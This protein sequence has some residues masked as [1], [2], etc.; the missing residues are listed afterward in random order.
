MGAETVEEFGEKF[1]PDIAYGELLGH[2]IYFY[3]KNVGAPVKYVAPEFALK[4]ITKIPRY[5]VLNDK[6]FDC[7]RF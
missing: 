2:T 3:S 4:D 7:R 5:K 6:D 1:A